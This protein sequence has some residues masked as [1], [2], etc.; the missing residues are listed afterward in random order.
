LV[1]WHIF[2]HFGILRK[3][4]SGNPAF[5]WKVSI[6]FCEKHVVVLKHVG[7]SKKGEENV[8]CL[9]MQQ[10]CPPYPPTSATRGFCEKV[11]QNESQTMFLSKSIQNFPM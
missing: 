11:T 10:R 6:F 5:D 1:I 3:E 7:D 8:S 2:P 4:K 9:W